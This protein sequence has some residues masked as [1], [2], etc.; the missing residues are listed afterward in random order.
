M[1]G[2]GEYPSSRPAPPAPPRPRARTPAGPAPK[3]SAAPAPSDLRAEVQR[4][5]A[6]VS[7]LKEAQAVQDELIAS[8]ER[9]QP[10]VRITSWL[11]LDFT[12]ETRPG[13][14]ASFDNEHVY[15]IFSGQVT[16]DWRAYSEI[17]FER[18]A[19]LSDGG[20]SG[21]ILIEQAWADYT[22]SSQLAFRFG[23]FLTP[24][25]IWNRNHW[26]PI[27]ETSTEP[28]TFRLALIPV[29][30]TGVAARG[31][32]SQGNRDTE[33]TA[34]LT[35]GR[36]RTPHSADDNADK[37][38][39]V[40]ISTGVARSW[41]V[42]LSGFFDTDGLDANRRE[43]I[44]VLW[45]TWDHGPWHAQSEWLRHSGDRTADAF[46]LQGSRKLARRWKAVARFDTV[47]TDRDVSA[48]LRAFE[49]LAGVNRRFADGVLMK[50]EYVRHEDRAADRPS[51]NRYAASLSIL[52]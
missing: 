24:Y 16:P 6:Q 22:R 37:A 13:A 40:D 2:L 25:G 41:R 45:A 5:A 9:N 32:S 34:Y 49:Y 14:F 52:F 12:H 26:D 8:A 42:G 17:E 29:N 23:K 28:F 19:E 10:R 27:T 36:G 38:I 47:N 20:G 18:G 15:Y 46:Y 30:Q 48:S 35:N 4:L 44:A 50:L 11:D 1:G 39:G 51:Y 7:E 33:W 21:D 31:S 3:S 43:D